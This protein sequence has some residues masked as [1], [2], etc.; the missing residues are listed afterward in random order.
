MKLKDADLYI[1]SILLLDDENQIHSSVRLRLGDNYR[2]VDAFDPKEALAIITR[3]A[4]DLCIVDVQMPG[5]DGL[6][7]IETARKIDPALSYVIFSGFDT[8]E[9]LRR[10]IPLQVL[11]FLSKPLPDRSRFERM[12][13]VWIEHTRARRKELAFTEN[14]SALV[15]DL[16]LARIEREVE[17]TASE[18]ARDA[19]FQ[20]AGMLT[21][22]QALLLNVAHILEPAIKSDPKFSQSLRSLREAR[23][24]VDAASS[25][26]DEYFNSAY[27]NR[28]SSAAIVDP[29]CRHAITIAQRLVHGGLDQQSV[30]HRTLGREVAIAGLTGMDFLLLLVPVIVQALRLATPGTTSRV[31]CDS[32]ARL[33]EAPR[34]MRGQD[35]MWINRRNALLSSPGIL[36]SVLSN[37]DA[38]RES[39][40]TN[41]LSGN[42]NSRL[43]VSIRGL[44][45]GI[46]KGKGLAGVAIRP[47]CQRLEILVAL[48]V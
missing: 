21:T 1:P 40:A 24:Q 17:A 48:P 39:E 8:D 42:T 9:N 28:D 41:W 20:T 6:T 30:D 38:L 36:L 7:F 19:L 29:C 45:S 22:A 47:N 25:I 43:N 3:E 14:S 13:P 16:E 26:T 2:L 31:Q 23:N 27:A 46:Q 4:L 32:L 44:I 12:L 10:A 34:G 5:M 11:E 18:S 37:A 35:F 33:D 15:R